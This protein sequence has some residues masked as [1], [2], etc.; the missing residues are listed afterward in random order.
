MARTINEIANGMKV[1]FVR[2]EALRNAFGLANYNANAD[3]PELVTYYNNNFSLVSVETCIIYAVATGM[4]LL[5]HM[6]DWFT[7]D[8]DTA[9]SRERYGHAGWFENVAKN[10]QYEDGT[11]F[12]LD[13]STGVYATVDPDAR[14]IRHASCEDNGFGVKLKVAKGDNGNLSQLAD[15]ELAAF[16]AY[17]NRLKPA[18]IPVTV[19]N[20]AADTLKLS[21]SIYY[22]PTIYSEAVATSTVKEVII[23]YLT[24]IDF[25]GQFVTMDMVDRLQAVPGLDIIE[26]G[27]VYALH[28]GYSYQRIEN[29]ARYTP[30]AGYMVLA[31]DDELELTMIA[32][33]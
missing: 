2:S 4:A 28:A 15:D 9:I 6:M 19:I 11:D 20:K 17:I 23:Q 12:G 13:E 27:E 16:T 25:N 1:E 7:E 29:D 22:D 8:V 10:F 30:V 31:D 24:D 26:T 18:G 5:E 32:N 3:E 14:I 33:V 21:M